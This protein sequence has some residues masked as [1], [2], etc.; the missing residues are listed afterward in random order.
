[1]ATARGLTA[2]V[3]APVT[4]A[5]AAAWAL[6][7]GAQASGNAELLGHDWLLG[8]GLATGEAF[9][10]HLAAWQTM[11]AAMM[12]PTALPLIRMFSAAAARQPRPRAAMG[13]FLGG[14]VVVW[15]AFGAL[16]FTGDLALHAAIEA[17]AALASTEWA[18]GGATLALAGGF[19]FSRLKDACLRKCRHPWPFL[20]H[21]Y[22]RGTAGAL[23]LGIRHGGY[24]LGCCW[25]LMLVMFA[26]GVASLVWMAA[27]TAVM[28]HEK[29]RPRG[30]EGVPV[31][32][33][34]LLAAAAIVLP[35]SAWSQGLL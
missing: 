9:A 23:R 25:A 11:V 7:L 29:T 19:Q 6:A 20:L 22:E 16:A 31:T 12:L 24:C 21:H 5:I 34:A 10:V 17:S 1:M 28:I 26:V 30:R 3:P 4:A 18:I 33:T 13:T 2:G 15:G 8:G 14:Y 27:L 35:Y 32:G